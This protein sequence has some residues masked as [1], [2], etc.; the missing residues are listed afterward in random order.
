MTLDQVCKLT[1]ASAIEFGWQKSRINFLLGKIRGRRCPSQEHGY[2]SCSE[3]I[4][5]AFKS[6][7]LSFWGALSFA[8]TQFDFCRKLEIKNCCVGGPGQ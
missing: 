4:L 7:S 3:R 6:P 8:R 1:A 2:G 5:Q